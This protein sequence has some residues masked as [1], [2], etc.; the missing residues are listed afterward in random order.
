VTLDRGNERGPVFV[1]MLTL[2]ETQTTKIQ[3]QP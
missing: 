2:T 1:D 3:L